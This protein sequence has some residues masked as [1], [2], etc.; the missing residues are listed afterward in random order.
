M[1]MQP[2][3]VYETQARVEK[4]KEVT[5]YSPDRLHRRWNTQVC[6]L[7]SRRIS[8]SRPDRRAL[9]FLYP[10]PVPQTAFQD[11]AVQ[12]FARLRCSIGLEGTENA[13]ESP[14][15]PKS[16]AHISRLLREVGTTTVGIVTNSRHVRYLGEMQR[17]PSQTEFLVLAIPDPSAYLS[18]RITVFPM[19]GSHVHWRAFRFLLLVPLLSTAVLSAQQNIPPTSAPA[20]RIDLDVVVTPKSGP[21]VANLQQQDF[22]LFDNKTLQHITSFQARDGSQ[23]PIHV[24]LVIDAVNSPYQNI[25]YERGEIDK[26]LR[27]NGGHLAQPMALAFFTDTGTQVQQGF[28]HGRQRTQRLLLTNTPSVCATSAALRNGKA[29]IAFSSP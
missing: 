14:D 25:A 3:D 23:D 12:L 5:G 2:G 22:T 26:F 10:P 4:L 19:Q 17:P 11:A 29:T 28:L 21:P 16:G 9:I 1:P 24:I 8:A 20:S 18:P 27:A 6:G 15:L 13:V 7:V